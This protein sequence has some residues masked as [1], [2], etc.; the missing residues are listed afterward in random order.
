MS[1]NLDETV[2]LQIR[3]KTRVDARDKERKRKNGLSVTKRAVGKYA[4]AALC[5]QEQSRQFKAPDCEGEEV[6][7][8]ERSTFTRESMERRE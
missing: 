1:K 2:R 5:Q 6:K 3:E 4:R 7:M 8:S